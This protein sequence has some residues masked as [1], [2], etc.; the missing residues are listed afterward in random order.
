MLSDNHIFKVVI[1]ISQISIKN[2]RAVKKNGK[3]AFFC[4]AGRG[5]D[6]LQVFFFGGG[7]FW[8]KSEVINQQENKVLDLY[9]H[10]GNFVLIR[11]AP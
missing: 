10:I 6:L 5:M 4:L 1:V 9:D 7:V 2:I 3:E 8:V 11:L